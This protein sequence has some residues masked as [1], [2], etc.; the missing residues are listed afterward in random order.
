VFIDTA[1][2][3]K[4]LFVNTGYVLYAYLVENQNERAALGFIPFDKQIA[5]N[6]VCLCEVGKVT[7]A[8]ETGH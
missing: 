8:K 3:L 5:E 7:V 2:D 4:N 1:D 6:K